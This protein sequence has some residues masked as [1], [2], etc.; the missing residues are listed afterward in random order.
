VLTD[1]RNNKTWH[2]GLFGEDIV[3]Q[4]LKGNGLVSEWLNYA[5]VRQVTNADQQKFI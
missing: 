3:E 1:Q 2:Y 5:R 4:Y